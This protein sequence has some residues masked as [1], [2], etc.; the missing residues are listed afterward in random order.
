MTGPHLSAKAGNHAGIT[1]VECLLAIGILAIAVLG[2]TY[3]TMAGRQ[4]LQH[5]EEMLRAVRLAEHLMEEIASRPY[6]GTGADRASFHLSD[7]HGFNEQ[8]NELRDFA[9]ELYPNADQ[10]FTRSVTVVSAAH[11]V[12]GLGTTISGKTVT[13]TIQ[14]AIGREWQLSRFIP[15]PALP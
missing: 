10:L 8:L 14:S 12:M 9:S 6:S 2:A 3:A 13:I 15:E 1:L 4:H 7:Y 11:E 5:G